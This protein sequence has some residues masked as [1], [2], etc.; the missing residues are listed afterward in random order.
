M[1]A[2]TRRKLYSYVVYNYPKRRGIT[3]RLLY[4][5]LTFKNT[6]INDMRRYLFSIVLTI[7]LF[8]SYAQN[9]PTV[10][11]ISLQK[12]NSNEVFINAFAKA[13]QA[14]GNPVTVKLEKGKYY[15]SRNESVKKVYYISNTTSEEEDPDPTKHIALHLEKLNNIT[16]DGNGSTLLMTGEMTSFVL[17]ECK[18]IAFKN[19]NFDYTFPTQTEM[20]I[21][22]IGNNYI[23]AK[24]HPTS[25]YRINNGILEWYG[26]GW[27]FS[28]GIAQTYDPECDI[29]WRS[30]T[31]MD[32]I[33]KVEELEKNTLKLYYAKPFE[34]KVGWTYQMR[35]A[36][37]DEVAGFVNR[38]KN[39]KLENV[40]FYYLGNFGVVCQ[41]SEN[42][43]INN[44]RFAPDSLG[45]RTNA[46]FADFLQVSGCKGLLDVRNSAFV[47]A[48]DDPINIHGT[49]LKIV[50]VLNPKQIKVRFMH[51]QTHGFQPF[52]KSDTIAF[53]KSETLNEISKA[54]VK[55]VKMLN[56]QEVLLE[57][58]QP[59]DTNM[60]NASDNIAVENITWTPSVHIANNYFSRIPTRGI[61]VTTR[62]KVIID[63]NTFHRMQM[64]GILISDDALGWYESGMVK[65]VLI[66]NNKFLECGYPVININ[67]ENRK[68]D[69]P[70]HENIRI[71]GNY[72]QLRSDIGPAINSKSVKKLLIQNNTIAIPSNTKATLEDLIKTEASENVTIDNN[73]IKEKASK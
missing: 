26:D 63:N 45:G 33:V 8:Q 67:P 24:V 12:G 37:R 19:I 3:F 6:Y 58:T 71:K 1:I 25:S 52:F 53:I 7:F 23:I 62:R 16:I 72:F 20:T 46:G 50:K 2:P 28:T 55:D 41:F 29:T 30:E 36:V 56:L 59:I 48:H 68:I 57:L 42:I 65:D 54:I 11:N 17:N 10:I 60:I 18:N 38:S 61:L 14:K 27:A 43:A 5:Y 34:T 40:Q 31:P 21:T 39:I 64:S 35:D 4:V 66:Q 49:H 47:G 22:E 15:F 73:V 51:G 44:T 69:K 70:V 32:N 13:K 9:T